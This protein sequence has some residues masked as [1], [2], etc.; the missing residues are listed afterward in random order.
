LEG[1]TLP[2]GIKPKVVFYTEVTG[3]KVID[4][5]IGALTQTDTAKVLRAIYRLEDYG[6]S[7]PR[8]YARHIRDKIWELKEDRYRILYFTFVKNKFVVLRVFM[9]K[10]ERTPESE[11]R[12]AEKRMLDY[13]VR[14]ADELT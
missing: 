9:K 1:E 3:K 4:L 10:T 6:T 2:E 7:L 5:E 13:R 11:I 8:R 12:I 14:H